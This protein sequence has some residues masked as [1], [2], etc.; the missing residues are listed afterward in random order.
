MRCAWYLGLC[1]LMVAM[2]HAATQPPP[3]REYQIKAVFLYN[4]AQ[5]VEWPPAVFPDDQTPLIIG[6]LGEDPFGRE[7]DQAVQ[8][9]RIG[10]RPLQVRR[11]PRIEDV[12]SCQI[13]FISRSETSRLDRIFRAL[14]GKSVLT[15][16]EADEFSRRGGMIRLITERNRV[17]MRINREAAQRAR[18]SL[19]SKLLRPAEL[20]RGAN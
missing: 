4:F 10:A 8:G 1:G 12:D 14:Q 9:E 11:Y 6:V 19:S 3:F 16:G 2:A 7:L 20:V 18:L 13:L 5:F 17:R 15:V